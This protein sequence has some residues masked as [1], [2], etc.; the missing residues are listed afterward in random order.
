VSYSGQA[1][2]H[3]TYLCNTAAMHY[4]QPACQRMPGAKIDQ[5]VTERL[6]QSL[7]PAQIELSMALCHELERQ[8]TAL[9]SQWQRRLEGARY[10]ARLAQR[11]YQQ[12]D[13]ENRLVVRNLEVEWESALRTLEQLQTDFARFQQQ[14]ALHLSSAQ[15]QKLFDLSQNLAVLWS[16][17]TT[18]W[19]ERKDLIELL[20]A[21]VTLTRLEQGIRVQIRWHTNWVEEYDLPLPIVGTAPTPAPIVRRIRELYQSHTDQEVAQILNQEGLKTAIGN[22]FTTRIVGDTRRRNHIHK[23]SQPALITE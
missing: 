13:P 5:L 21:D 8:Q 18:T 1:S 11:R 23:H 2:Q 20:I 9:S 15:R 10:A 4:A 19:A 12:V 17:P 6:L 3:I 14:K 7:T 16:V 22:T